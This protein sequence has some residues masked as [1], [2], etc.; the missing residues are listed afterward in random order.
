MNSEAGKNESPKVL[1]P[2][3]MSEIIRLANI[4]YFRTKVWDNSYWMGLK[5]LQ[6]LSEK[7]S[8]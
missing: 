6:R 1:S 5:S 7:Q 3:E 8:R 2:Q 4:I